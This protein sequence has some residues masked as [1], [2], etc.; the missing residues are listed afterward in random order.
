[1]LVGGLCAYFALGCVNPIVDY[2][3]DWEDADAGDEADDGADYLAV[4][5]GVDSGDALV[6][7][8]GDRFAEHAVA[9][10]HIEQPDN[11]GEG[12]ADD[13]EPSIGFVVLPDV[14]C[15]IDERKTAGKLA[16]K[17]FVLPV[18]F[19]DRLVSHL[20]EPS[21]GGAV[22]DRELQPEIDPADDDRGDDGAR[23]QESAD[24]DAE[25]LKEF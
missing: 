20:P 23:L 9:G 8:P 6:D 18:G 17:A 11:A 7:E 24:E 13:R 4:G 16:G 15:D 19:S 1:M 10:S 14:V 5:V 12:V 22:Q 25:E 21:L 3:I 2:E